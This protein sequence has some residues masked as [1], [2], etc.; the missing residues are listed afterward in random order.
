MALEVS[1]SKTPLET[2]GDFLVVFYH[3]EPDEI[4][5]AT[6]AL[7]QMTI[8]LNWQSEIAKALKQLLAT[9]LPDGT[10]TALVQEKANRFVRDDAQARDF[11]LRVFANNNLASALDED[12]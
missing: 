11:L 2:V 4:L 10:L 8:D 5:A 9:P 12:H 1:G 7:A 6:G 3:E